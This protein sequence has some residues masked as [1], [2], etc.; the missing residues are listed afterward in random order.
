MGGYGRE[1]SRSRIALDY[2]RARER[3]REG[4][5]RAWC[6]LGFRDGATRGVQVMLVAMMRRR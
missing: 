4:Y 1:I 3:E 2:A 5:C 6:A